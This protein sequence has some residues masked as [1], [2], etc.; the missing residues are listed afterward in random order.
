MV[1]Y[2]VFKALGIQVDVRPFLDLSQKREQG[3]FNEYDSNG[4][5][6]EGDYF[7]HD[8]FGKELAETIATE[9]STEYCSMKEVVEEFPNDQLKV[10]WLNEPVVNTK[11]VQFS[12]LTV[13]H[14]CT[15]GT[16][17]LLMLPVRQ[18]GLPRVRVQLLCLTHER[19]TI[20]GAYQGKS[21]ALF[22]L[23]SN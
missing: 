1:T 9:L 3:W 6:H 7:E 10:K 18:S 11:N 2:E 23:L 16:D 22:S 5:E 15:T 13:S 14:Y 12:Y 17:L 19:F 21:S 4:N 8:H 20:C